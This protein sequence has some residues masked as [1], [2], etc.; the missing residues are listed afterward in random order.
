MHHQKLL[1]SLCAA[2]HYIYSYRN[3]STGF[4]VAARQLCPLTVHFDGSQSYDP[5]GRKYVFNMTRVVGA[6]VVL[7]SA[8]FV[9]V[10]VFLDRKKKRAAA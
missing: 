4:R 8:V 3:A 5:E 1:F 10:L 2:C 9:L 7:G 6:L